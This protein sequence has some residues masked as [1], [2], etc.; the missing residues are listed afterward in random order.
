MQKIQMYL[1]TVVAQCSNLFIVL[2]LSYNCF[3]CCVVIVKFLTKLLTCRHLLFVEPETLLRELRENN[4][5]HR[6]ANKWPHRAVLTWQ[7]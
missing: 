6:E 1:I 5:R 4:W 7:S 2:L 3:C